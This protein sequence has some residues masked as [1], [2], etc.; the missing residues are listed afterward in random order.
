[1]GTAEFPFVKSGLNALFKAFE[2]ITEAF[3]DKL[4]KLSLTVTENI[5]AFNRTFSTACGAAA[6]AAAPQTVEKYMDSIKRIH[7]FLYLV[8]IKTQVY[9]AT[10]HVSHPATSTWPVFSGSSQQI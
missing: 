7:A 9:D 6:F 5:T 1:M 3:N 8:V 10:C 4:K 2:P